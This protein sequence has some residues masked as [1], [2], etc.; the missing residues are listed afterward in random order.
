MAVKSPCIDRCEFSGKNGWCEGCVRTRK[1]AHEWRKMS[2]FHQK[3][4]LRALEGRMNILRMKI[5]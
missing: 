3:A 2:P 4:L 1:E 5:E